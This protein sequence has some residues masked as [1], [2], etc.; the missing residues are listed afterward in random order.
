MEI[1]GNKIKQMNKRVNDSNPDNPWNQT[2][3]NKKKTKHIKQI[4]WKNKQIN[5]TD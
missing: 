3:H 4:K 5:F 1:N 2:I